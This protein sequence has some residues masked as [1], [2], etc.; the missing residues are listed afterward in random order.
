MLDKLQQGKLKKNNPSNIKNL[1]PF[2]IYEG[3]FA[4]KMFNGEWGGRLDS[5]NRI[6]H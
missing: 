6:K 2:R 1:F 3:I 5:D 4:Q